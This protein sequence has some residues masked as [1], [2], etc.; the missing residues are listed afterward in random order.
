[1][2]VSTRAPAKGATQNRRRETIW[3]TG[4]NSRSREGSDRPANN[5]FNIFDFVSTRAP[6]KGAT[7]SVFTDWAFLFCFNSR[8][9]EGS[10]LV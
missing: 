2:L 5:E 9:R 6:A 7:S 4:F 10:D 3:L 1:M 8:S